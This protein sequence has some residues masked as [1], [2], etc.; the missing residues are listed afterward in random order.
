VCLIFYTK[1][2]LMGGTI[3]APGGVYSVKGGGYQP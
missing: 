2:F 1:N 3:F